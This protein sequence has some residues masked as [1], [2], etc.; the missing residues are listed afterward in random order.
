MEGRH[1]LWQFSQNMVDIETIQARFGNDI[2]DAFQ[3]WVALQ[4]DTEREIKNVAEHLLEDDETSSS[5]AVTI[6]VEVPVDGVGSTEGAAVA[7]V[8]EA[9]TTESM[10]NESGEV[11]GATLGMTMMEGV[12]E[13]N[14]GLNGCG[15]SHGR[16]PGTGTITAEVTATLPDSLPDDDD[17]A[18]RAGLSDALCGPRHAVGD[19]DHCADEGADTGMDATSQGG[20]PC[21]ATEEGNAMDV[22]DG[23]P[24]RIPP[25]WASMPEAWDD[26]AVGAGLPDS[27]VSHGEFQHG[28]PTDEPDPSDPM[29]SG[30]ASS[31]ATSSRVRESTE[32]SE[33][34]P[35]QTNLKGWLMKG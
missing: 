10:M 19:D 13:D 30:A 35:K 4:K 16:G 5:E 32:G 23:E 12:S 1:W 26:P 31:G 3:M 2:A 9:N 18:L 27:I 6:P 17:N 7:R 25:A 34:A 15:A 29:G 24:Y 20:A 14:D 22:A 21:Q 33:G 28:L 8:G 11:T